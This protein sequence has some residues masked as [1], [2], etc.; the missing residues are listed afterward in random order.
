MTT[1]QPRIL[2]GCHEAP[3]WGGAA[4]VAHD[5]TKALQDAGVAAAVA[6]L[7][8][9]DDLAYYRYIFGESFG[10]PL[11]LAHATVCLR[12][13]SEHATLS[14]LRERVAQFSPDVI[15]AVG[16]VAAAA[17]GQAAPAHR[18]IFIA[19]G[20]Q[21][22]K[23][24]I[25]S[26]AAADVIDLQRVLAR[27]GGWPPK[28]SPDET[29][30][31]ERADL[32][33]PNC[34][35]VRSLLQV[36]YPTCDGKIYP[37]PLS[38]APWITNAARAQREAARPFESRD[39]DV[40]FVASAWDRPEKNYAAVQALIP[41]LSRHTVH[42][43]GEVDEPATGATFHG[44]LA[45]RSRLFELMGRSKTLVCP[46]VFDAA[47][48][49]LFEASTLG[50]NVVATP[51][52]GNVALCHPELV[53]QQATADALAPVIARSLTKRYE[54]AVHPTSVDAATTRLLRIAIAVTR[55]PHD[56]YA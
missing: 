48:G 25:Q 55:V 22:A 36:F 13:S 41:K 26:G 35:L 31:A 8:D 14:E 51:N 28:H 16:G 6:T 42:V 39:I 38:L 44:L 24:M 12:R 2:V 5:L 46:S 29:R 10:N 49:V 34:E 47:P 30:A 17:L 45:D 43:V 18:L 27:L 20:C 23:L 19:A 1:G 7:I 32:I 33:V 11:E 50:C 40:L 21:Q 56:A 3:G 4:T 52:C 9:E 54:P 15:L 53:A 37:D